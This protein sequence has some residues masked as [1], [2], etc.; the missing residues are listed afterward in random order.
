MECYKRQ[1]NRLKKF[2][3]EININNN[4]NLWTKLAHSTLTKQNKKLKKNGLQNKCKHLN[5]KAT[6]KLTNKKI[7]ANN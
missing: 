3:E 6:K 1:W 4:I 5:T 2:L 7:K